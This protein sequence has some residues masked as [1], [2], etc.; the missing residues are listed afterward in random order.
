MARAFSNAHNLLVGDVAA[1]RITGTDFTI[2]AKCKPT[3][4]P[5]AANQQVAAKRGANINTIAYELGFWSQK[6]RF[7][8]SDLS[9]NYDFA[10]SAGLGATP[11]KISIGGIKQGGSI[12]CYVSGVSAGTTS[13]VN[14]ASSSAAFRI[15]RDDS[16]LPFDG[17]ICDVAVWAKALSDVEMAALDK[18]VCPLLIRPEL[19]RGYWPIFGD[20]V[21][22]VDLSG[23]RNNASVAGTEPPYAV[24]WPGGRLATM[25]A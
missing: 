24:H 18:G 22:E 20:A 2:F 12:R 8:L 16:G 1:L 25:A 7:G 23:N 10:E 19:L 6:L 3:S 13:S 15:G 21:P 11:G 5:A 4:L 17:D 14:L 9:T